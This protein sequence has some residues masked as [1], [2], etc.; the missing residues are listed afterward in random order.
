[1]TTRER[2]NRHGQRTFLMALIGFVI[3]AGGMMA[4]KSHPQFKI[5]GI[6]GFV[7]FGAAIICVRFGGRCVHCHRPVGR[8]WYGSWGT[9]FGIASDLQFAPTAAGRLMM[10]IMSDLTNRSSQPLA[11][12]MSTFDL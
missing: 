10:M 9:A 8:L 12:A 6:S 3:F 5:I 4:S 7:L 11:V 2:I 1:M